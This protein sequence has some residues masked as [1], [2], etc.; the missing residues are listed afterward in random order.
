MGVWEI[1]VSGD[2]AILAAELEEFSRDAADRI[3]TAAAMM[4]GA[5]LIAADPK[6]LRWEGELTRHNA[7]E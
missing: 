6:I 5:T 3:I 2:I 4:H 7:L 1:P